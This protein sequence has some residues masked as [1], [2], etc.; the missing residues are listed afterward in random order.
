MKAGDS[1]SYRA[2]AT[3]LE[4]YAELRDT[5]KHTR[6]AEDASARQNRFKA[7]V[8]ALRRRGKQRRQCQT[9]AGMPHAISDTRTGQ[10]KQ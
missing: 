8:S 9:S 4:Q 6:S 3:I 10:H 2:R 5:D 1:V 7:N